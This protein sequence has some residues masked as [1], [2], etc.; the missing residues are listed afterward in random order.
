MLMQAQKG[1]DVIGPAIRKMDS[2]SGWEV[3]VITWPF[4]PRENPGTHCTRAAWVSGPVWPCMEN[5][6]PP[7]LDPRTCQ[8]VASRSTD[9]AVPLHL[10]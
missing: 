4:Y 8:P 9:H 6:T 5:L 2:R 1:G 10:V 3:S 7:R